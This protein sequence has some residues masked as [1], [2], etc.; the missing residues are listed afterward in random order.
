[1]LT[2]VRQLT[3]S[4]SA[5]VY[6]VSLFACLFQCTVRYYVCPL[7]FELDIVRILYICVYIYFF[8]WKVSGLLQ[9]IPRGQTMLILKICNLFVTS[10]IAVRWNL[11]V[12]KTWT[13]ADDVDG[14]WQSILFTFEFIY[15]GFIYCMCNDGGQWRVNAR[16]DRSDLELTL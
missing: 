6:Y 7:I 5:S 14:N 4:L 9:Y 2:N 8:A 10:Y 15:F 12:C 1:M 16:F 11:N 13:S 3:R